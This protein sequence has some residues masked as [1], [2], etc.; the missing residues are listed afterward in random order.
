[1]VE[2]A[3]GKPII[4]KSVFSQSTIGRLV[5]CPICQLEVESGIL[6]QHANSCAASMFGV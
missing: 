1:M 4:S 3:K 5:A 2:V 6:E